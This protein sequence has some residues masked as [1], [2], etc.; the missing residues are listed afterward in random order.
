MDNDNVVSLGVKPKADSPVAKELEE[1]NEA[2]FYAQ[3]RQ[4]TRDFLEYHLNFL[5]ENPSFGCGAFLIVWDE[6]Q[7]YLMNDAG[8]FPMATMCGLLDLAKQDFIM[9]HIMGNTQKPSDGKST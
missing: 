9:R 3:C 2:E 4:T 1:K 6:G 5:K 8:A 7:S